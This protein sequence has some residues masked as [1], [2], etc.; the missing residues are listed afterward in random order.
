MT[1]T[2]PVRSAVRLVSPRPQNRGRP[3]EPS[4]RPASLDGQPVALLANGKTHGGL[5]LNEVVTALAQRH[6]L[7]EIR[8]WAK[9]HPSSPPTPRQLA[10]IQAMGG[11]ML[12]AVGDC[13]SCSSCSV[14][15]GIT[16][17]R[18]GIPSAV[19]ITEPFIPTAA[20]IAAMNGAPAFDVAVIPHPVTSR[21]TEELQAAARQVAPRM[22]S[23]L[24]EGHRVATDAPAGAALDPE[25]VDESLR[26]IRTALASDGADLVLRSLRGREVAF[27]LT[28]TD[29]SCS[30]CVM[31][32]ATI[33][34]MVTSVLRRA[35]GGKVNVLVDDARV[36]HASSS[37][38]LETDLDLGGV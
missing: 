17:E 16:F 27:E 5:L 25:L 8:R 13:G 3:F 1:M 18:L 11:V 36:H 29:A 21:S 9:P 33:S 28:T 23:I 31:P 10:E 12:T 7:G 6:A 20:A 2:T 38:P 26:D 32:A 4:P 15:D 30:D 24:L 14:V 34:A 19:L 22:E 35:S 37:Q